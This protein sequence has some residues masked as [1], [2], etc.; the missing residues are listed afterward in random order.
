AAV[1][2]I[3]LIGDLPIFVSH[4]SSDVWANPRLFRLDGEGEPAVMAGVPPDYFS[5]TGQLWGNPHYNWEE[6][7]REGY[8]W[9]LERVAKLKE[10]VDIIRLD[11]FRGFESY[12]EVPQ[13]AKTAA[14][15]R[16]VKG[17]G[18]D[19]FLAVKKSL[20]EVPFI[21]EDLG[22]I[23]PE[24]SRLKRWC[25]YPGMQVLQFLLEE[26]P[27]EEYFS[28]QEETV[29]YTGTHD[30]DTIW[31]WYEKIFSRQKAVAGG[32]E[33]ICRYFIE[34]A[35]KSATIAAIIPLQDLLCLGEEGRMNIP[36][37][38]GGNNWRWR[39]RQGDLQEMEEKLYNLTQKYFG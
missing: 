25:G 29:F 20:G 28:P 36:G 13:G 4:D 31:S 11:H 19:I 27:M 18:K 38:V 33:D 17:P 8:K 37:T 26:K 6:M 35:F 9:W 15:G 10:L 30:N 16:W 23:T 5:E 12:W 14:A 7:K 32:K 21:A 34:M 24:V 1:K 22:I 3:K 39:F 2:G